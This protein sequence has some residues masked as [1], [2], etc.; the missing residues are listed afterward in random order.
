[1]SDILGSFTSLPNLHPALV[2]FPIAL[3]LAALGFDL[4]CLFLRRQVWLDRAAAALYALGALGAGAAYLAG[5]Q[6]ADLSDELSS[7]RFRL[8]VRTSRVLWTKRSCCMAT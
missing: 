2:H 6:A 4:A 8:S 5:R 3:L 1:M 7:S